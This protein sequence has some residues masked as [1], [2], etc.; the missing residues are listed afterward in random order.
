VTF[1]L[2]FM[3]GLEMITDKEMKKERK[4]NVRTVGG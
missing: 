4:G 1:Q 3:E 2:N